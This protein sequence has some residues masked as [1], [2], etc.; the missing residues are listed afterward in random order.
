MGDIVGLDWDNGTENGNYCNHIAVFKGFGF[1]VYSKSF[2][3]T[4]T[5]VKKV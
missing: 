3:A 2:L 5:L 4:V 1:R